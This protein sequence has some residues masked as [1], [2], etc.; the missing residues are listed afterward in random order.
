MGDTNS[1]L[2]AIVAKRLKLKV[3]HLEAGNRSYLRNSPE[4]V[5]RKIIDHVSD[6]NLPYTK[7]SC[8]NLVS[9]GIKRKNIFVIGNPIFEV[10]N[11][12]SKKIDNSTILKKLNL[13]SNKFIICTL[14]REENIENIKNFQNYLNLMNKIANF[15]KLKIIFPTHPRTKLK[16][17]KLKIKL[18]NKIYVTKPLG[19]IDFSCLEKNSKFMITDSGTVQE[20]ASI[21]NKLCLVFRDS[22]ERPETLENG[23]TLLINN[24]HKNLNKIKNALSFKV[25]YCKI[26][27]YKIPDVSTIVTN[28][29][30]SDF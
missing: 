25:N 20:E 11:Y 24:K 23:N 14:H 30:N 7:R 2:G 8:E 1:S 29:I 17:K 28:I 15:F 13:Q 19:F 12:Y 10:I 21:L 9:E 22:T 3:F 5:N 27:E 26:E 6:I 16:L 4:E 18:S